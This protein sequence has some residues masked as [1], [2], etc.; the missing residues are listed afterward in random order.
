METGFTFDQKPLFNSADATPVGHDVATHGPAPQSENWTLPPDS[1]GNI[2]SE[3]GSGGGEDHGASSQK[4]FDS[5]NAADP[6]DD[7]S[8]DS[9]PG[10][11]K[12]SENDGDDH[13]NAIE[14][15]EHGAPPLHGAGVHDIELASIDFDSNAA[16]HPGGLKASENDGGN[17]SISSEADKHDIP[18]AHGASEHDTGPS[19]VANAVFGSGAVGTHDRGDSF[20]FKLETSGS[21][22][23]GLTGPAGPGQVPA[24]LSHHGE[25]ADAHG[26]LAAGPQ[27]LD[28]PPAVPADDLG[29]VPDHG[30]GHDV[31]HMQHDLIV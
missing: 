21:G 27:S 8:D 1:D 2:D 22:E 13:S 15:G 25:A 5:M 29:I 17:H 19:L 3:T 16:L 31:T 4:N 14:A 20:H 12:T 18:P 6:H 28:L 9:N 11:L 26:P 10:D 7:T 24:S 30:K 23:S